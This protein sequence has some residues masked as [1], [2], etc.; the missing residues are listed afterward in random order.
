MTLL[1]CQVLLAIGLLLLT[2]VLLATGLLLLTLPQCQVLLAIG[3]LPW[4]R[5]S[6]AGLEALLLAALALEE[7]RLLLESATP[8]WLARLPL[9]VRPVIFPKAPF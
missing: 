7:L 5:L 2:Q 9:L 8:L 3:L 6:A 4:C 1:R